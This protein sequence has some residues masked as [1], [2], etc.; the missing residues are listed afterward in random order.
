MKSHQYLVYFLD[1]LKNSTY[2][3]DYRLESKEDSQ[4]FIMESIEYH[5]NQQ[6]NFVSG[7]KGNIQNHLDKY[8]KYLKE[9]NEVYFYGEYNEISNNPEYVYKYWIEEI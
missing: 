7:L 1:P 6:I 2:T 4:L 9:H 3:K 5:L 8:K